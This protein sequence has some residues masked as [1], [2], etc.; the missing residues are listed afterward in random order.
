MQI[1]RHS[2]GLGVVAAASL[3]LAGCGNNATQTTSTSSSGSPPH[4]AH[5]ADGH[6]DH[7]DHEGHDEHG[8]PSEGPHHGHLIEL[9]NEEYHAEMLHDEDTSTVT[10]YILDGAAK[11]EVA[12]AEDAVTL[13]LMIGGQPTQFKLAARPSAKDLPGQASHFEVVDADLIEALEGEE[14]K[15]RLRVTINGTPYVG[16]I[17]HHGHDEHD[18][19]HEH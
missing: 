16:T 18:E 14:A 4:V 17:E 10:I 7:A 19:D 2:F 5:D 3:V 9:G 1:V 11:E 6:E 15:G 8:H 13:N 12:V